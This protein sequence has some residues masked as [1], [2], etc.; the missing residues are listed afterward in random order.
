MA[1]ITSNLEWHDNMYIRKFVEETRVGG[2]VRTLTIKIKAYKRDTIPT[3]AGNNSLITYTDQSMTKYIETG[4]NYFDFNNAT[5]LVEKSFTYSVP[6]ADRT[7]GTQT[8][9]TKS[10]RTEY[11]TKSKAWSASYQVLSD[12]EVCYNALWTDLE[13][14]DVSW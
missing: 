5:P 13:A 11:F 2:E 9:A 14:L 4:T 1:A 10:L 7:S 6:E 8:H 3:M 12:Y